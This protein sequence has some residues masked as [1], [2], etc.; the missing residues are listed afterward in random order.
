MPVV[1]NAGC[2]PLGGARLPALFDTWQQLRVD[3][4]PGVEPDVVASVTDLSA[5]PS[6]SANAVWSAHCV[7]HLYAHEVSRALGEFYRILTDDGFACIVVPDLQA[8]A[9]YIAADKLHAPI[10]SSAAGPRSAHDMVYGFGVAIAQGRVGMAH[11]CGFTPSL[12]VSRFQ[13][14]PFG[15]ILVRRRPSALELVAV[16]QKKIVNWNTEKRT[17]LLTA[18]EL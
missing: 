2:G 10:Y 4:D 3:L 13:E 8:I 6:E 1:V 15:E 17:A 12:M 11:R 14:L 7:E 5:I 18:L 9:S 16:V